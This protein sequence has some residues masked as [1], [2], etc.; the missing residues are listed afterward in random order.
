[1][2]A[3]R[4]ISIGRDQLLD[5]LSA[6][7]LLVRPIRNYRRTTNSYHR[8]RKYRNIVKDCPPQAPLETFVSDIT[9]ISTREGFCY[10]ALVT[11]LYSRKIVGWDLCRT[12]AIEGSLR[13]LNMALKGLPDQHQLIHHSDRG[14]QYCSQSYVDLLTKNNVRISM[15]EDNHCYENAVAERVNGILKDEFSLGQTL[16]SFKIAL[17]LITQAVTTY[18][19]DRL[20]CSLHYQTPD[21]CHAAA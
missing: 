1:M 15:T 5:L 21:S 4:G 10:L 20:H 17:E 16:P 8:F 12:L 11:D 3:G 18:N 6:N 7:G 14:I 13:A 2:L 9:Y 19:H